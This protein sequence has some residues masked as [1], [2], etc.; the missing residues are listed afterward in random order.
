[1]RQAG[2]RQFLKPPIIFKLLHDNLATL[3]GKLFERSNSKSLEANNSS[4]T[5][6]IAGARITNA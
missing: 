1:M 4:T 5:S 3:R 6:S 2:S